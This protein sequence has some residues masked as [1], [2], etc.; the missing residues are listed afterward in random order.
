M[1]GIEERLVRA[2][3][4]GR[5]PTRRTKGKQQADHLGSGRD[6][7]DRNWDGDVEEGHEYLR[8]SRPAGVLA[9][10]LNGATNQPR[11]RGELGSPAVGRC[12][13]GDVR[14]GAQ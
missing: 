7:A 3:R 11:Q 14:R 10:A 1:R 2:P 13:G 4:E 8:G 5:I 12:V 9:G 6:G